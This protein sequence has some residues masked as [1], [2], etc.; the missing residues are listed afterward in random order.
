MI[1]TRPNDTFFASLS[2]KPDAPDGSPN[3]FQERKA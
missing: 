1:A 3:P 2:A